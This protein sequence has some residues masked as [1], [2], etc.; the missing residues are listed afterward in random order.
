MNNEVEKKNLRDEIDWVA[1]LVPLFG[2][3]LLGILFMIFPDAS[4]AVLEGVRGFLGDQFSIYYAMLAVGVFLCSVYVAFSKYGQIVLGGED[5]E[6]EYSNFKWGVMIFTSTMAADIVFY[7]MIEWALYAQE[8]YLGELGSVQKWASTFPLFHWGPIAWS[9][10]IMLAVAFGFMLH[11]RKVEKQKFSEACRPLLGDK[12]DGWMGKTIDLI[13]IFALIAGTATTFSLATPLLSAA[14]SQVFGIQNSKIITI[15]VLLLIAVVYTTTVMLGMDAVSK[16]AAICTYLFFALLGYFLFFGG[17]TVYILET[18]FSAI[19]NLVQN[20]IGMSTWLDPLRETSFPQKW[21]IY[22]WSYWMVW[23]V[24][25]PFFIGS[26]SKGRT[27]K[28]TVLGGYAWGIAGTFTAFI[29]LGN[30]GLAQ[31]LKHGLDITGIL[32]NNADYAAAI[33]K[34][35]DTMPLANIGLLLLAVTMIAFYATTFDA[36]T[37]VVSAYSYKELEHTH[38]SD[39]RVRMFWSLVFILFPIAL[40]FSENSMYNLQSVAIIAALPI[41]IIIV[42]IIASFFKDAKDYLKN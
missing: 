17:E 15:V 25:T 24:A 3:V 23:C 41:G 19:G 11:N 28:N 27:V 18:G 32:S 8:S 1:T 40:I 6:V 35:F 37:L 4:S 16:L 36:L 20:F 30:Y 26:I 21:T 7:A 39:K 10:Y 42:M 34:I 9:F 14:M 33:L 5:S 22:Y 29:I 13:A 38:G 2:V 31:Q 12:V